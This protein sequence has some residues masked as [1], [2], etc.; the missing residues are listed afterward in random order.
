MGKEMGVLVVD[1]AYFIPKDMDADTSSSEFKHI[2]MRK[3]FM[4]PG[5]HIIVPASEQIPADITFQDSAA[6]YASEAWKIAEMHSQSHYVNATSGCRY[7]AT[8]ASVLGDTEA[9]IQNATTN[10]STTTTTTNMW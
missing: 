10:A 2:K 3:E 9:L 4:N 6:Y 8:S 5:G 7:E 1:F